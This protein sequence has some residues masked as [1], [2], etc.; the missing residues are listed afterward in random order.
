MDSKE[1][2][3]SWIKNFV[4]VLIIKLNTNA[5]RLIGKATSRIT[6]SEKINLPVIK[7]ILHKRK[8]LI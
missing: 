5:S 7:Y 8:T 4:H 2:N 3:S 6:K 1:F